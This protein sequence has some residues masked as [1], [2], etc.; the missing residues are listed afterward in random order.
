MPKFFMINDQY[1]EGIQINEHNGQFSLVTAQMND[2][3]IYPKW[4]HPSGGKGKP[5]NDK[6][7][8]MGS[9][10]M[11]RNQLIEL[12]KWILAEMD[13]EGLAYSNTPADEGE[14]IPF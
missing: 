3:K 2:G 6:V 8:P 5:P 12:A 11:E 1:N 7:I 4:V 14:D 13:E 9:P 10:R